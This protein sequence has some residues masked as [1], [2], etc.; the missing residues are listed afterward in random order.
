MY[1]SVTHNRMQQV[2][3]DKCRNKCCKNIQREMIEEVGE[4][5]SIWGETKKV[6]WSMC[7]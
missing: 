2:A 3:P 5:S 7:Q 4:I 6:S 1:I